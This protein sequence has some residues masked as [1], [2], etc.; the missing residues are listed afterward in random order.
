MRRRLILSE[1]AQLNDPVVLTQADDK[2]ASTGPGCKDV[3]ALVVTVN[4]SSLLH[5]AVVPPTVSVP[6]GGT[7]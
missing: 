7:S 1:G 4:D 2:I 5:E 6:G 3:F